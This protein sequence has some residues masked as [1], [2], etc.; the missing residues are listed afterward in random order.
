MCDSLMVPNTSKRYGIAEWY[1]NDLVELSPLERVAFAEQAFAERSRIPVTSLPCP[2]A[3]SLRPDSLCNKSGGVCSARPYVRGADGEGV[4]GKGIVTLCPSRFLQDGD[5]LKWVAEVML[6]SSEGILAIKETPFLRRTGA[7]LDSESE[8]KAG[9]IDWIF[10]DPATLD[11]SSL[12]WCAL[13]TQS[14]YFSGH[15]MT[16]DFERYRSSGSIIFPSK[17]RRPDYRSGGPKRLSPQL[18]IKVPLLARWGIKSA[19]LV[20]R[21]FFNE[22]SLI[23]EIDYEGH[24]DKLAEAEVVWFVCDYSGEGK[25]ARGTVHYS[26]LADSITALNA[27]QPIGKKDFVANLGKAVKNPRN[28]NTK[29]F[30]LS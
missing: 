3:S 25:L 15:N 14:L 24:D 29:Y 5:L 21:F 1:G 7:L 4:P 13:E 19:V 26:S 18:A 27:A 2:F 10:V 22:M 30:K 8:S 11:S 6:G 9:R 17:N 16:D 20:D 28:E 12:R 23:Q